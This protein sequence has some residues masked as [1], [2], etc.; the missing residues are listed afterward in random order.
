MF[1]VSENYLQMQKLYFECK[2]QEI[3]ITESYD[4][5]IRLGFAA[6]NSFP[7]EQAREIFHMFSS[8][9]KCYTYEEADKKL[10]KLVERAFVYDPEKKKATI[11][12]IIYLAEEQGLKL[13]YDPSQRI[14]E[15]ARAITPL[16]DWGT[17]NGNTQRLSA[18][19]LATIYVYHN[20]DK[21]TYKKDGLTLANQSQIAR[22]HNISQR[23]V[24][25]HLKRLDSLGWIIREQVDTENGNTA[26][27]AKPSG[28]ANQYISLVSQLPVNQGLEDSSLNTNIFFS[29]ESLFPVNRSSPLKNLKKKREEQATG[30]NPPWWIQA[31]NDCID[32]ALEIERE[33]DDLLRTKPTPEIS[34]KRL[35]KIAPEKTAAK[36]E[37]DHRNAQPA[38]SVLPQ[39]LRADYQKFLTLIEQL[40]GKRIDTKQ[41]QKLFIMKHKDF[42]KIM[43]YVPQFLKENDPDKLGLYLRFTKYERYDKQEDIPETSAQ[44]QKLNERYKFSTQVLKHKSLPLIILQGKKNPLKIPSGIPYQLGAEKRYYVNEAFKQKE[45][46]FEELQTYSQ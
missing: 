22:K 33:L 1:N 15:L 14:E 8:L 7:E 10:S 12:T 11:G 45:I 36:L 27:F 42:D 34:K 6:I 5:W 29:S 18:S 20:Y 37:G 16:S 44:A 2:A 35:S 40:S 19:I 43:A 3:S 28:L 24:S 39:K 46:S 25:S 4:A 26:W 30:D 31:N 38:Q 17:K 23:T 41:L 21:N 32:K 9:D 13:K